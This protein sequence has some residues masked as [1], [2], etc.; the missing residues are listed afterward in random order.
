MPRQLSRPEFVALMAMLFAT[1]AF[2]IDAMLPALPEIAAELTPEDVN[3]AQLIVTSFVFGMGFGTLLA[4][5]LSDSF[6]R[7]PVIVAGAALYCAAAA[8]A[9]AAVVSA[10]LAIG[11]L[12]CTS[13]VAGLKTSSK[14]PDD[15]A[16][17]SPL[18]KWVSSV[19]ANSSEVSCA[20]NR[21][22]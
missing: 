18:M 4:G 5:P 12:Y 16:T 6:G 11:H 1:I 13:P 22:A 8:L 19:I 14:R 17:F 9:I 7:K 20:H 15:P 21:L 3:R 10:A 2:S